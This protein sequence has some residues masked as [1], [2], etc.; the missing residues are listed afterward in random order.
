MRSKS[1]ASTCSANNSGTFRFAEQSSPGSIHPSRSP[2][3]LHVIQSVPKVHASTIVTTR[4]MSPMF[5]AACPIILA[6]SQFCF[7]D[8]GSATPLSSTTT[9]SKSL[10]SMS[11]SNDVRSSSEREQHAQ[12]FCNSTV[13]PSSAITLSGASLS[14][15]GL[16]ISLASMFTLA[17]SFTIT[18]ILTPSRF[19]RRFFNAVVLP[20]PRNPERR[21]MGTS[22]CSVSS[23]IAV[24][25]SALVGEAARVAKEGR[26]PNARTDNLVIAEANKQKA[27]PN[28]AIMLLV[29]RPM[30]NG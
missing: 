4:L 10:P 16:E 23:E 30:G 20:E 19:S 7:T 6:C 18:P 25:K 29:G 17:T 12:P 3:V 13:P 5:V 11:V 27:I 28:F 14:F 21:V 26:V 1:A 8:T 2:A 15:P 22:F 24:E 9:A